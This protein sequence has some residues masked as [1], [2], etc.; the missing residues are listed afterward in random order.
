MRRPWGGRMSSFPFDQQ[1]LL[2]TTAASV[3]HSEIMKL[4]NQIDRDEQTPERGI[5]RCAEPGFLG[6]AI[7]EVS[8]RSSSEIVIACTISDERARF[9]FRRM[10][11]D[12]GRR[13]DGN[14]PFRCRPHSRLCAMLNTSARK[15]PQ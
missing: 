13:R 9:S 4:A 2:Q 14:A 8:G 10:W 1:A 11:Q 7:L 6:A 15:A 12:G 3:A 5:K